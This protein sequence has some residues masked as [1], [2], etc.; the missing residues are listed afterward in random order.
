[1]NTFQVVSLILLA[2]LF[3]RDLR[4]W[5]RA[6]SGRGVRMLRCIVW[7]GAAVA[8]T[9]PDQLTYLALHLGI[10]R[11]ADLV[12][13]VTVLAFLWVSFTLYTRSLR[14]ERELTSLTRHL[15]IRDAVHKPVQSD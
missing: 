5:V 3:L 4:K 13:Y 10:H 14:L 6:R 11:G 2:V 7:A 8:I 9:M 12:L 15:A 1:M